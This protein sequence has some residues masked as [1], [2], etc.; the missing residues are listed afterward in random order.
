MAEGAAALR[1]SCEEPHIQGDGRQGLGS[2]LPWGRWGDSGGPAGCSAL[3]GSCPGPGDARRR[4][5]RVGLMGR[6]DAGSVTRG[7][8]REGRGGVPSRGRLP[9]GPGRAS[10]ANL[11]PQHPRPQGAD[12]VASVTATRLGTSAPGDPRECRLPRRTQT[13][14]PTASLAAGVAHATG[15]ACGALQLGAGPELLGAKPRA[16]R[17]PGPL[18]GPHPVGLELRVSP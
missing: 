6:S 8:V 3:A 10:A 9:A 2:H 17:S 18:P 1:T 15:R 16:E 14:A 5:D 13:D 12:R 4:T 11:A 7:L